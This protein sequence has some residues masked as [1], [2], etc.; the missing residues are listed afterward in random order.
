MRRRNYW[1]WY[2]DGWSSAEIYGEPLASAEIY[3]VSPGGPWQAGSL[4]DNV[5]VH[6]SGSLGESVSACAGADSD[7]LIVNDDSLITGAIEVS[8]WPNDGVYICVGSAVSG[9]IAVYE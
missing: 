5:E 9:E 3:Y 6:G 7:S 1:G 8:A 4:V 2:E